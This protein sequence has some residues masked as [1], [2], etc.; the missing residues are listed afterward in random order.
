MPSSPRE[1]RGARTAGSS[2]VDPAPRI[3]P[4]GGRKA[5]SRFLNT[6]AVG[7]PLRDGDLALPA[8]VRPA[9]LDPSGALYVGALRYG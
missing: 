5:L 4:T 8:L 9:D 7:W 6:S 1:E 3:P 2:A